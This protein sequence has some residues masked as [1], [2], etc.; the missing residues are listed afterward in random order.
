V[1]CPAR[2]RR[3]SCSTALAD[4]RAHAVTRRACRGKPPPT[5]CDRQ[6]VAA[7]SGLSGDRRSGDRGQSSVAD[8]ELRIGTGGERHGID[9]VHLRR[10]ITRRTRHRDRVVQQLPERLLLRGV[11]ARR[12]ARLDDRSGRGGL[13]RLRRARRRSRTSVLRAPRPSLNPAVAGSPCCSRRLRWSRPLLDCPESGH[14]GDHRPS[15]P[16]DRPETVGRNC[17]T[18]DISAEGQGRPGTAGVAE[19][20]RSINDRQYA[21]VLRLGRAA[22]RRWRPPAGPAGSGLGRRCPR[23]G[24]RAGARRAPVL[25]TGAPGRT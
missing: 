6:R 14:W 1:T 4:A 3:R 5:D 11:R 18:L 22:P 10:S 23:R 20:P 19:R 13:P 21:A 16:K 12:H 2:R 24:S 7:Q 25:P 8:G 15:S 9:D 17:H